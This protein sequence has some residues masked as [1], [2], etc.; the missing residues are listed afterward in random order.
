[1]KKIVKFF[2]IIF[3]LVF[4]ILLYARYVGTMGLKTKEYAIFTTDL[5]DGFDGLK[6]V[7]FSDIHYN[8]SITVDKLKMVVDEINLINPDIVVFTGDLI[9]K[10]GILRERDYDNLI[11]L[12][13]K[14]NAKYG[15][16]A[17]MGEHDYKKDK[18]KVIKIYEDANFKYL[19]NDY[20]IVYNKNNEKIF[21]GGI[22]NVTNRQDDLNKTMEYFKDNE[23]IKYKIILVHEPDISD[24]IV[25]D[26][27]VDLI[28]AGHSHNGQVRIPYVGPLYTPMYGKKYYDN[29]YNLDGTELYVSSGIGVTLFDFRLFNHPSINFYRI[30]KIENEQKRDS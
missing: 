23:D 10:N 19:A 8:R 26:Y 9:D 12:L 25:K 30:N 1:M 5:P 29:Y 15:K 17:V 11:N 21:I 7:H 20:D 22:D 27:D 2:L 18:D 4:A 14:I 24:E 16:Y 13:L 3:I 6:I 28:L